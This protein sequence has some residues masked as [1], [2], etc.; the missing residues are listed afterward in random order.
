MNSNHSAKPTCPY[1]LPIWRRH[2]EATSPDGKFVA[3]IDPAHE[4]SMGNPTSGMLCISSGPHIPRCNPSFVW[5]DDSRFL[6]VPHYFRRLG[7][8]LRQ[9]LLMVD[10]GRRRTYA[11]KMTAWYFQ[12][13]T[14]AGG[15]LIASIN[16]FHANQSVKFN[17]LVDLEL[18]FTDFW[19]PWPEVSHE[20]AGCATA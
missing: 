19:V 9:R 10:F 14:F 5:S 7:W 12:P 11:S 3:R 20:E 8:F 4:I 17:V 1:N 15:I 6:A 16:P 13:E 18:A 2:Y